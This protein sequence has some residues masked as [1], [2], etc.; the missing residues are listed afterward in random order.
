MKCINSCPQR[1]IETAHGIVLIS[2]LL[3]DM[4]IDLLANYYHLN[5]GISFFLFSLICLVIL[6]LLY[7]LQSIIL[8]NRIIGKLIPYTSLTH[9]KFWGRYNIDPKCNNIKKPN[10][11]TEQ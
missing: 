5:W 8:N 4:L 3:A 1:A 9:Y 6:L 7:K 2:I 10:I 11:T